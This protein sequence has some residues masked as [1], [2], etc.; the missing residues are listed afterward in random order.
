MEK[1]KGPVTAR[2]PSHLWAD[3]TRGGGSWWELSR[4]SSHR[5][6]WELSR[7]SSPACLAGLFNR[8]GKALSTAKLQPAGRGQRKNVLQSCSPAC[9]PVISQTQAAWC[10][11]QPAGQRV[12]EGKE[13]ST[14]GEPTRISSRVSLCRV[15]HVRSSNRNRMVI[16]YGSLKESPWARSKLQS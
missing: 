10:G 3:G 6:W 11:W 13:Q 9:V 5:S 14:C 15:V 1:N 16:G 8:K 7:V 2:S 12:E 4:V